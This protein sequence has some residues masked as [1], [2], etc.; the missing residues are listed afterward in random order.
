MAYDN[1]EPYPTTALVLFGSFT[2]HT[3][4]IAIIMRIMI[5]IRAI[6]NTAAPDAIPIKTKYN[7]KFIGVIRCTVVS[8]YPILTGACSCKHTDADMATFTPCR[9]SGMM[10]TIPS[11]P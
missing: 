2:R 7:G 4:E 8:K 3:D 10:A 5:T 9:I 11:H 6:L 1:K